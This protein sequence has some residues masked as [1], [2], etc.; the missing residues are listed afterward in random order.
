MAAI[1]N[2]MKQSMI[3]SLSSCEPAKPCDALLHTLMQQIH[4]LEQGDLPID[5][6]YSAS[7]VGV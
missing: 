2:S 7:D 4:K 6:Y 5:D 3:M 1:V